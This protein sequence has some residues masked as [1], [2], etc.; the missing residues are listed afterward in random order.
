VRESE[1]V[2]DRVR[3]AA[4]L[5]AQ[6]KLGAA[7]AALLVVAAIVGVASGS[8]NGAPPTAAG[9]APAAQPAAAPAFTLGALAAP[10]LGG[11]AGPAKGSQRVSLSQYPGRP[12]IVNFWA[13]WCGPCQQETPLLASF[14][15][16][17]GGQVAIVG[18]DS[19]DTNAKAIAFLQ[20]KGV[21]YPIGVDPQ[22]ATADAYDVAA[23][24]Q[25]FFLDSA[26]R[27]VDR[28]FGPLTT[29]TLNKGVRLMTA[30]DDTS[31][32]LPLSYIQE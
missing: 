22:L 20:A 18:V 23:F 29:A 17:H 1:A 24:P 12:L 13:S 2:T 10:G 7:M 8:L 3:R 19:N 16:A 9:T 25:T 6:H 30:K 5:V 15:K 26:H 21:T 31:G 4:R 28:V 11:P 27:V 14:Y 32:K